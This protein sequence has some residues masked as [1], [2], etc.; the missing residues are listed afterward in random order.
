MKKSKNWPLPMGAHWVRTNYPPLYQLYRRLETVTRELHDRQKGGWAPL[1][2]HIDELR[3]ISSRLKVLDMESARGARLD[4]LS[5]H[6]QT[7]WA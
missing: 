7:F 3:D 5:N 4:G 2:K 1:R 6:L